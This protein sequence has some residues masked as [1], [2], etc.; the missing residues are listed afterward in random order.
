MLVV[1]LVQGAGAQIADTGSAGD[2]AIAVAF[3]LV[4]VVAVV[5]LSRRRRHI[6]KI[7]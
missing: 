5:V 4:T 3:V 7:R 2:R 1:A 6:G